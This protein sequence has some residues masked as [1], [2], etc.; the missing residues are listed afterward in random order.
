MSGITALR[1]GI[2]ALGLEFVVPE[3]ERLPQLMPFASPTASTMPPCA[4]SCSRNIS[5]KSAP[6]SAPAAGK[7]WRIGLMGHACNERNVLF[8]LGALKTLGGHWRRSNAAALAGTRSAGTAGLITVRPERPTKNI[9]PAA[10]IP[11]QG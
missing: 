2:E 11:P 10:G 7:V 5:S 9:S 1:A 3:A 6:V 4:R 8:C